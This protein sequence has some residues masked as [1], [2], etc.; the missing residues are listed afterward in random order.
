MPTE[1]KFTLKALKNI[2][3]VEGGCV[4]NI[5]NTD[6]EIDKNIKIIITKIKKGGKIK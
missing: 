6:D 4:F 5:Y 1:T 3:F 2:G